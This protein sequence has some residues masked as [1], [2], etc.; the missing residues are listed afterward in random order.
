MYI[1]LLRLTYNRVDDRESE[2]SQETSLSLILC[3]TSVYVTSWDNVRKM[4]EIESLDRVGGW[5]VKKNSV[6][7]R[8]AKRKTVYISREKQYT[9]FIITG[10]S[11]NLN[12]K[13]KSLLI[14]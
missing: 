2:L 8:L 14:A 13:I 4:V 7:A 6:H 9:T 1:L 3:A 11:Q 5:V 10:T 12:P